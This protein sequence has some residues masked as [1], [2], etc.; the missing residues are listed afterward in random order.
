MVQ[1]SQGPPQLEGGPQTCT[2]GTPAACTPHESSSSNNRSSTS[3]GSSVKNSSSSSSSS[4]SSNSSSSSSSSR[5]GALSR[6]VTVGIRFRPAARVHVSPLSRAASPP[7]T[8]GPP[9]GP[10][11]G[12]VL[13]SAGASSEEAGGPSSSTSSL[14]G[15]PAKGFPKRPPS[16]VRRPPPWARR[17]P[18]EA[19]WAFV[20]EEADGW[21]LAAPWALDLGPSAR[22]RGPCPSEGPPGGGGSPASCLEKERPPAASGGPGRVWDGFKDVCYEADCVFGP[23]ATNAEVYVHLVRGLVTAALG[24][25]NAAFL[26]YGQTASGKTHTIFGGGLL[27]RV[28]GKGGAP[29]P[30]GPPVTSGAHGGGR[31]G[32]GP[33]PPQGALEKGVIEMALS[34]IFS[35]LEARREADRFAVSLSMVEVYQETVSDLLVGAPPQGGGLPGGPQAAQGVLSAVQEGRQKRPIALWEKPD[36]SLNLGSLGVHEVTSL[37]EALALVERGQQQRR[38][39]PTH[40]NER[41]SRSH[42]VL[43]VILTPKQAAAAA[44][45]AAGTTAAATAAAAGGGA[46]AT[47]PATANGAAAAGGECT[48]GCSEEGPSGGPPPG[49]ESAADGV[50]G[51]PPRG[52]R[53]PSVLSLVDLAG[54]EGAGVS[55]TTGKTQ[56]E[57]GAINRSLLAL[58]RVVQALTRQQQQ[59]QQ[60]QEGQA[61]NEQ[62]AAKGASLL[63]GASGAPLSGG[64]PQRPAGGP[65]FVGLR[66]SKLTRLLSDCLG[67]PCLT[68]VLCLCAPGAPYYRQTAATLAFARRAHRLP[69]AQ[70]EGPPEGPPRS[71][72]PRAARAASA[73]S[74]ASTAA[75]AAAAGGSRETAGAAEAGGSA[76]C[77]TGAPAHAGGP[78]QGGPSRPFV[79]LPTGCLQCQALHKA[80]K[81]AQEELACQAIQLRQL[82]Y[83]ISRAPPLAAAAAAAAAAGAAAATPLSSSSRSCSK[84]AGGREAGGADTPSRRDPT[85]EPRRDE[86]APR[87]GPFEGAPSHSQQENQTPKRLQ[88]TLNYGGG[89][90][91]KPPLLG[92]LGVEP[93]QDKGHPLLGAPQH[94]PRDPIKA[95][96]VGVPPPPAAAALPVCL[97]SK[98]APDEP[99][100]PLNALQY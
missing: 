55:L 32:E 24:G 100:R 13:P 18:T 23:A 69:P 98:G 70:Q 21:V 20:E 33:P 74:A 25:R 51:P 84:A 93:P 66:D 43:R 64:A 4:S 83:V 41:S 36:G 65:P 17:G 53:R 59:Q 19:D 91:Y 60:Q 80:L 95:K 54:S 58:S 12:A 44:A 89:V 16:Q 3:S 49:V 67:G 88:A 52:P 40:L 56:R 62:K 14:P 11:A 86:G 28:S 48:D 68:S 87:G 72:R 77:P 47:Q 2:P 85:S 29:C 30:R 50:G 94:T 46:A 37:S 75:G 39:A 82:R 42:A 71:K 1:S 8:E 35:E 90:S 6:H 92:P 99:Q 31:H 79:Y 22:G 63:A 57:G 78:W 9:G 27:P 15:P 7:P 34:D 76:S 45:A 5:L 61:E 10:P 73:E 97:G 26:A 38:A 96:T 81:E